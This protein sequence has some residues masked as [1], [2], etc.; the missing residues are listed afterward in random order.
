MF[1]AAYF[2]VQQVEG[3]VCFWLKKKYSSPS[4][5]RHSSKNTSALKHYKAS[6]SSSAP[7]WACSRNGAEFDR[8]QHVPCEGERQP[9]I[10]DESR[11]QEQWHTL[12][13][14]WGSNTRTWPPPLVKA[15]CDTCKGM[16]FTYE[17]VSHS[18]DMGGYRPDFR[19]RRLQC[20]LTGYRNH[21]FKKKIALK[22]FL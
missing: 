6:R 13:Q 2:N 22:I 20:H 21:I 17:C 16:G 15:V 11:F 9:L 3:E 19:L 5:H 8:N 18:G 10:S 7:E 12:H 4:S 1:L 14:G